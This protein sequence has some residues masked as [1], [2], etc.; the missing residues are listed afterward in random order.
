MSRRE[1]PKLVSKIERRKRVVTYV[2]IEKEIVTLGPVVGATARTIRE[3]RA[4]MRLT[5]A[6]AARRLGMSRPSLANIEM[7]RQRIY[8]ED[9]WMFAD[10]F[11]VTPAGL[12][13]M[14]NSYVE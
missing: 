13:T 12:V 3:L 8:L 14:I 9:A 5:Q 10:L 2:T 6:E 1:R 11:G 7:G 4:R